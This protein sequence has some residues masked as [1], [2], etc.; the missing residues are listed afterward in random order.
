MEDYKFCNRKRN[1][2]VTELY[3]GE[4]EYSYFL[5]LPLL[6]NNFFCIFGAINLRAL[7]GG[8]VCR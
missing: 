4:E 7:A 8:V 3:D 5:T 2:F 1:R 6:F